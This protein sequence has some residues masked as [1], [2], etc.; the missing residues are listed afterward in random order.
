MLIVP[1]L[2]VAAVATVLGDIRIGVFAS[3]RANLVVL[4]EV[5]D[6]TMAVG[7]PTR[8]ARINRP[9][10]IPDYHSFQVNQ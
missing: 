8:A 2:G 6:Y 3:I 7:V 1:L 5:S 4:K 10:E 9:E